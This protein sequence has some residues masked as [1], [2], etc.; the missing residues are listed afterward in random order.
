MNLGKAKLMQSKALLLRVL[1]YG[2]HKESFMSIK[3]LSVQLANQIAA[4]EV[5]ERPASVVKELVENA[6]DAKA[7][8]IIVEIKNAGKQLIKVTDNG[9]GIVKD[10]L[11]LALAPHATSKIASLEDLEAIITLGFRGE[12]L[13]SIASV[14][15]LSLTSNTKDQE[16][17]YQVCV[18]GAEQH[19]V[20]VPAA[21]GVGTTIEV[22]ELFFNTPARRRFLKSDKTE[23]SHIKELLVRLALVNFAI[24]F[25][26]I[27]DGK[28]VFQVPAQNKSALPDRINKLLG[29]EFKGASWALDNTDPNF[30]KA[31]QAYISTEYQPFYLNHDC[32]PS[33][34]NDPLGS[35]ILSI[36]GILLKPQS[37]SKS[38]PDKLLTF[39]NGRCIS[40]KTINHALREAYL[41][42]VQQDLDFKPAIRGVLFMECDPYSVDVNVHPRKDE[43][44]FHNPNLIHDC[45]VANIK[46][47]MELQHVNKANIASG[48]LDID[49]TKL[50]DPAPEPDPSTSLG[51]GQ[52][53]GQGQASGQ[54][55]SQSQGSGAFTKAQ[56]IDLE[57]EPELA[58][59]QEQDLELEVEQ[60]SE[61]EAED[62]N[63]TALGHYAFNAVQTSP[64]NTAMAFAQGHYGSQRLGLD[65][66]KDF[67]NSIAQY[68]QATKYQTNKL[69]GHGYGKLVDLASL[70]S[71]SQEQ[72][73]C[74]SAKKLVSSHSVVDFALSKQH[75]EPLSL[76][77]VLLR[78]ESLRHQTNLSATHINHDEP[79]N[80]AGHV[81]SDNLSE[82][83]GPS[84]AQTPG[85]GSGLGTDPGLGLSPDTG[86]EIEPI[87][88][89]LQRAK[90][91]APGDTRA[92][93]NIALMGAGASLVTGTSP[94][95]EHG[96]KEIAV[97]VTMPM[98]GPKVE[99]GEVESSFV[100]E[101]IKC[102]F[103][104][105]V[106]ADVLLISVDQRY[107]MIRGSE[108]N[109]E[110]LKRNYLNEVLQKQVDSYHLELPFALKCDV[111]L[112][113]A[114]KQKEVIAAAKRCGFVLKSQGSRSCVE[115]SA[116]PH[117]IVKSNLAKIALEALSLICLACEAINEEG[118]APEQLASLLSRSKS[119]SV[120][121]SLDGVQ[122]IA[123]LNKASVITNLIKYHHAKELNLL[124]LAVSLLRS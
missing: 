87:S 75:Q 96:L 95:A 115:L 113:K 112:V 114:C 81:S 38:S 35:S 90:E 88:S 94:W 34:I 123:K 107:F 29:S 59:E 48:T 106:T 42:A 20:I 78:Q 43:V 45:I 116:I 13:A 80:S 102:E 28:V 73:R 39:L 25:K 58:P 8:S 98:A 89:R 40:D 121:T 60:D 46:A 108:L 84:L 22:K 41:N 65:Y 49:Y 15:Q 62:V 6:V 99:V 12:A 97:P 72:E 100:V 5:V 111:N 82:A 101:D 63:T 53:P 30:I 68:L 52:A 51:Q 19:P 7:S 2:P 105:L 14:S 83:Q 74:D 18:S 109:Y 57:L 91:G 93:N 47:V 122:L 92:A 117:I 21:H 70:P 27:S 32:D 61:L 16:H 55:L 119:M 71:E 86:Q 103:L 37:F 26:F 44:R 4:G 66:R 33:K 79:S 3:R 104:S 110:I 36:H 24:E 56:E 124:S 118:K 1:T 23:F 9:H 69:A 67:T 17:G 77:K 11:P 76:D 120:N 54:A 10:D 50:S 64:V 85:P 31:Y